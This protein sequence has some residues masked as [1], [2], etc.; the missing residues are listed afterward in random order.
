[1]NETALA[2]LRSAGEPEPWTGRHTGKWIAT[3]DPAYKSE[4]LGLGPLTR[5][6]LQTLISARDLT[7]EDLFFAISA[8]GGMRYDHGRKVW[9]YRE[10]WRNILGQLKDSNTRAD[11]F[12]LFHKERLD[13]NLQ[14]LGAAYFTK[15]IFF[16]RHD[17]KG[18]IMDRWVAQSINILY[19]NQIVETTSAG[20]VSD[21]ND[22]S[23]YERFCACIE[24]V[25]DT[26]NKTP[27]ETEV[28]LFS[29]GGRKPNRWR[30]YVKGCF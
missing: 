6:D 11:A 12:N 25:A 22:P 5:T 3:V 2:V 27:S 13:N 10:K 28:L 24:E 14:N 7:P 4:L 18:Y 26:L 15:F 1:M 19:E 23:I 20:W 21:E 17:L 9:E 8:W 30:A 29:A 16:L